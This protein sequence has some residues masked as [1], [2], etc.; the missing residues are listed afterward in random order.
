MAKRRKRSRARGLRGVTKQD[1]VALA[2]LFC[3]YNAPAALV[4]GTANYF[5]GQNPRFDSARF[6]A[7]TRACKR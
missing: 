5:K 4:V 7:A 1:F 6:A 3:E 2:D